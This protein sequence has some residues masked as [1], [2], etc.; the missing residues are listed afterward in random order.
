MRNERVHLRRADPYRAVSAVVARMSPAFVRARTGV[1]SGWWF[2]SSR[3]PQP[4]GVGNEDCRF[5]GFDPPIGRDWRLAAFDPGPIELVGRF[6]AARR[7]A[8]AEAPLFSPPGG[9]GFSLFAGGA[10]RGR[11]GVAMPHTPQAGHSIS[12]LS[13]NSS[14]GEARPHDRHCSAA[15]SSNSFSATV[16]AFSRIFRPVH[17]QARGQGSLLSRRSSCV[18]I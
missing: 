15:A 4:H 17:R 5:R 11:M 14:M 18:C 16:S 8:L 2:R 13:S 9:H 10:R 3:K 1:R 6:D 12:P 7:Y